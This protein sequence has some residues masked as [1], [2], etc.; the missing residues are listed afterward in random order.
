MPV[1]ILAEETKD[2]CTVESRL[3]TAVIV[4]A[5]NPRMSLGAAFE[6]SSHTFPQ[7]DS[8]LASPG[9]A[10]GQLL[11]LSKTRLIPLQIAGNNKPV[12]DSSGEYCQIAHN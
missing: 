9:L 7:L 8:Q 10:R 11:G 6:H 12:N 4:G 3:T 1:W 5:L 2:T